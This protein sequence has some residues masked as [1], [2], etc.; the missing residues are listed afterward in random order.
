MTTITQAW[1]TGRAS[2]AQS[3]GGHSW[4]PHWTYNGQCGSWPSVAVYLLRWLLVGRL[5]SDGSRRIRGPRNHV[6]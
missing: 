3:Y 2:H 5:L 1:L 4:S 6:L